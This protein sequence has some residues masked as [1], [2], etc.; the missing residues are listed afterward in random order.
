M[1]RSWNAKNR[2]ADIQDAK[3]TDYDLIIVGGGVTGA[4]VARECALRGISFCLLEKND[5]GFGTSSRSSKLAH[6]GLR[7]LANGEFG[8][9]RESETER[10]WLRNHLPNL[11][12][13]LGFMYCSYEKGKDRPA[14]I[15]F[16]LTMYN[17]LS[18]WFSPYKNF[19]KPKYFKPE[20]V[21]EFEP[22]ITME[23]PKIGKMKMAGF[24]YD[25]NID[26]SRLTL[27]TIKESI[28][29]SNGA[30]KAVNYTKVES[31]IKNAQGKA[32]G[33]NVTDVLTGANFEVRGRAVAVCVGI[34]ND[35][36]MKNTKFQVEKIYPTK[37]VH[38]IVK[39]ERLGNRNAFG[40]R[41]FDDGRFFFVLRRGKYSVIGT[42]DT[43]YYKESKII[44]EPWCKKEDCDYLLNTVNRLFPHAHL[45]Y[46]DII[47]TYA[48]IRPLIKQAGAKNESAVSREH[49]I[50]ESEDGVVAIAGG[51]LT[52]YRR[53][54]EE[55]LFLMVKKGYMPAFKK[56]EYA[57]AGFSKIPFKVGMTIQDFDREVE[58]N[59]YAD[60]A[61]PDQL[62]YLHQQYGNQ[63]LVILAA[64]KKN[65]ALGKPLL[66]EYPFC[67]AEFQFVLEYENA[68]RLI[69]ILCRRT[70][71]QWQVWHYLQKDLAEKTAAI[72]A[73]YYG[74]NDAHTQKEIS[75]YM[76]YVKKTIWF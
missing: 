25:T 53:M 50:F 43:D 55:L 54:A 49:E 10:N 57:K 41:S 68:P 46:K 16:A 69:D 15:R 48:G 74:W 9:V 40:V 59:R 30:S 38:V 63:G 44:D 37:G 33:V 47:G 22:A 24:Y 76:D 7:Y 18:D 31:F 52:T 13:P 19:R 14:T 67:E 35:D 6:G 39:N 12:R 29:N 71:A 65:P 2:N 75:Y 17:I 62:E 70:E 5:F 64:M 73:R 8:I 60:F 3:K 4:G 51:K 26:D 28:E 66:D 23:D 72:M 61:T 45:T 20:F 32:C 36:V 27:E 21:H 34:W 56:K 42:T 58:K 1:A 11:V